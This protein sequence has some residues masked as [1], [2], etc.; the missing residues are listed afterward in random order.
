[1]IQSIFFL[2]AVCPDGWIEG[3]EFDSCYFLETEKM[4]WDSAEA[5]CLDDNGHLVTIS[6]SHENDFVTG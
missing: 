3:E 6:T 5:T 4:S 1:M 2:F